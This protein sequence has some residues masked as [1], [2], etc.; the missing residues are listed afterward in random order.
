MSLPWLVDGYIQF[1]FF[2]YKWD[3]N[4]PGHQDLDQHMPQLEL[5]GKKINS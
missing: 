1:E 2:E 4:E 3:V 5:V